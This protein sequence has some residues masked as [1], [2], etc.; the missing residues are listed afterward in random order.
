MLGLKLTDWGIYASVNGT[1]TGADNSLSPV[2]QQ[3]IICTND[4]LL[5]IKL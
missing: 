4:G 5:T 2:R 3:P 1:M